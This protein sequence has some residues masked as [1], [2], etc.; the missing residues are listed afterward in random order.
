[1]SG[2]I[3]VV[4]GGSSHRIMLRALLHGAH[5]D[6][7]ICDTLAIAR[8]HLAAGSPDLVLIDLGLGREP[9]L[10]FVGALRGDPDTESLPIIALASGGDDPGRI[11]ALRA[12]ADDVLDHPIS[13][14]I[15]LARIRS[16]LR[17]RDDM[18]DLGLGPVAQRVLGLA[19]SGGGFV[20]AGRVAVVSARPDALP[21]PIA[22]LIARLPGGATVLDPRHD[23]SPGRDDRVAPD[24]FVIDGTAAAPAGPRLADIFRLLSDLRSRPVSRHA[25]T[26]VILPDAAG[27]GAAM[28]YDLGADDLVSDRVCPDELAHRVRVLLRRKAQADRRRNQV[29]SGLQAAITDPLTGLYNRRYAMSDLS[30]IVDKARDT[31]REFTILMLDI[32]HFK[33]INDA[34]GHPVGDRVLTEVADRLRRHL[35]AVDMVARIGG[36]EFLV[37]L[38]DTG[39]DQARRAAERLRRTIEDAAFDVAAPRSA[40]QPTRLRP[41]KV[42]LSIGL[43]VWT[44]AGPD[45][46]P[47]DALLARADVALYAAKSAGR[48][49][50][51]VAL[52]AA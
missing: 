6:V 39:L 44:G 47:I 17:A 49:T 48:N 41:I 21:D 38:P 35:R 45:H 13:T 14:P 37:A 30:Q 31:G 1:M 28:A 50:V 32:D 51:E 27:D 7:T 42:T 8:A 12:G 10:A 33:A 11:A 20:P 23:L 2:R 24:L 34:H 15:L 43:A 26:M 40:D 22:G 16:L 3:L 25:A 5:Y 46:D 9:T 52:S 4:E 18:S 29:Q 19:E 36:E